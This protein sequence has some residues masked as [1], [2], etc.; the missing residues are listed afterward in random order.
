LNVNS[1]LNG[2]AP[3]KSL[4]LFFPSCLMQ[5]FAVLQRWPERTRRT[6]WEAMEQSYQFRMVLRSEYAHRSY[7]AVLLTNGSVY[8]DHLQDY[9][10]PHPVLTDVF[11]IQGT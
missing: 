2:Q 5:S 9:R 4:I 8:F 10:T 3:F 1:A 11:I 6:Q 7:Q